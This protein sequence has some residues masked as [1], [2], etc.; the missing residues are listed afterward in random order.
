MFTFRRP[1]KKKI[2]SEKLLVF[3]TL[4]ENWQ[5]YVSDRVKID[6]KVLTVLFQY[7]GIR[8]FKMLSYRDDV[9]R[10]GTL[11]ACEIYDLLS[12]E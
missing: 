1:Q 12:P 2:L 4:R 6:M 7:K 10:L 9:K 11:I 8:S 3:F 5:M